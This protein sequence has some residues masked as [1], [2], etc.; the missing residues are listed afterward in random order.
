MSKSNRIAELRSGLMYLGK[1]VVRPS[2][3]RFFIFVGVGGWMQV[4]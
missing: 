2:Y 3:V 1:G 4:E